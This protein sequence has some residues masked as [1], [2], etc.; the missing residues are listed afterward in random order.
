[1]VIDAVRKI[2]LRET[3]DIKTWSKKV[4]SIWYAYLQMPSFASPS[5]VC[6]DGRPIPHTCSKS[7]EITALK[8]VTG[9]WQ[10]NTCGTQNGI[11]KPETQDLI[12]KAFG[13]PSRNR[14]KKRRQK[15]KES[16]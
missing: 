10:N 5:L 11:I 15:K 3:D 8:A 1:M 4:G 12:S 16:A 14:R 6:R 13:K 9:F 7:A 2:E